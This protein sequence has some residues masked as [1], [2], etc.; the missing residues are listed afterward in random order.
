V[1]VH[2][3]DDEHDGWVDYIEESWAHTTYV[4]FTDDGYTL[5]VPE[6]SL[7]LIEKSTE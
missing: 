1:R 3:Y 7:E 4:I 5:K 6:Y 2:L